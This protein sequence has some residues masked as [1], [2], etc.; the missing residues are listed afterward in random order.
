MNGIEISADDYGYFHF[1]MLGIGNYE[2]YKILNDIKLI[3]H[4]ILKNTS[5]NQSQYS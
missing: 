4:N 1:W 5:Q 3:T 2:L